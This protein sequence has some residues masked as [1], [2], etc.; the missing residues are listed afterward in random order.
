MTLDDGA[1]AITRLEKFSV[2][3]FSGFAALLILPALA[4]IAISIFAPGSI[5]L[6]H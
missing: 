4:F 3:L 5:D 1:P 6:G 2:V